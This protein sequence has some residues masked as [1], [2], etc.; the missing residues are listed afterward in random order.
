MIITTVKF[1]KI[2]K[3]IHSYVYNI[4]IFSHIRSIDKVCINHV[5]ANLSISCLYFDT[6]KIALKHAY[7]LKNIIKTNSG[8]K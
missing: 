6:P 2:I 7:M 4:L 1:L 8:Q 5:N 3:Q